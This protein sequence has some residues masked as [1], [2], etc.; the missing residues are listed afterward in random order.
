MDLPEV[1]QRCIEVLLLQR[2]R[3]LLPMPLARGG[4]RYPEVLGIASFHLLPLR[5]VF[6]FGNGR[7]PPEGIDAPTLIGLDQSDEIVARAVV[8]GDR[9]DEEAIFAGKR[10]QPRTIGRQS[11]LHDAGARIPDGRANR[12]AGVRTPEPGG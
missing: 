8:A 11:D 9:P 10:E 12:L 2:A 3:D 1:K 7:E 5:A 4:G 6:R